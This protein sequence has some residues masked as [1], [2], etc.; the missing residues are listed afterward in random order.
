[1]Q[2]NSCESIPHAHGI[3][4]QG[5]AIVHNWLVSAYTL[6]STNLWNSRIHCSS[7]CIIFWIMSMISV[8]AI[9]KTKWRFIGSLQIIW[10]CEHINYMER[11]EIGSPPGPPIHAAD[12]QMRFQNRHSI[13]PGKDKPMSNHLIYM[14]STYKQIFSNVESYIIL[15]RL[16]AVTTGLTLIHT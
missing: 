13:I 14:H 15:A 10:D 16:Y 8:F 12:T 2:E 3:Y 9:N 7:P 6:R 4:F 1:M 5:E 11:L